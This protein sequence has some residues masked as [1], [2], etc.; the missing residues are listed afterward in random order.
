M[1]PAG[2]LPARA[3]D[4]RSLRAL[5]LSFALL[6]GCRGTETLA[7]PQQLELVAAPPLPVTLSSPLRRWRETSSSLGTKTEFRFGKLLASLFSASDGRAFLD[8]VSASLEADWDPGEGTWVA[9]YA[10]QLSLQHDGVHVPIQARGHGS[11][12]RTQRRVER[13]ALEDSVRDL[14]AQL[15]GL[16]ANPGR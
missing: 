16:L 4:H 13:D 11:S 3:L 1:N 2:S 9:T 14:Y 8:V 15:T 6:V 10:F 5:V 7:M 12:T